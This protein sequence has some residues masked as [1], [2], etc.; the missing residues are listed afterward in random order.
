MKYLLLAFI[1]LSSAFLL[2]ARA[3]DS[4]TRDVEVIA[5]FSAE[6]RG[7]DNKTYRPLEV[8][9]GKANVVVFSTVDCPIAN[10]YVPEIKRM[11]SEYGEK[12][13][14]FFVV[15][16][17]PT[18]SVQ[19]ARRHKKE[20]KYTLPIMLDLRHDFVRAVGVSRTPEAVILLPKGKLAYRGSID[21]LFADLGK[22]RQTP[23]HQYLRD[24]LDEILASKPLTHARTPAI[25]CIIDVLPA[26]VN[27]D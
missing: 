20:Y 25:G 14:K 27:D 18:L 17:D 21:D 22:K 26:A 24:S 5:N 15:H 1:S 19:A 3:D 10:Y 6:L 8:T 16:C 4:P 23:R 9:D 12:G 2:S 13:I 7:L 11:A